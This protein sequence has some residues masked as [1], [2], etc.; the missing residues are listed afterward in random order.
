MRTALRPPS[1]ATTQVGFE[2]NRFAGTLG[3]YRH[4]GAVLRE[5]DEAS[6]PANAGVGMPLQMFEYDF[7]EPVLPQRETEWPARD[8]PN[9]IVV[10]D[11]RF[12]GFEDA[13]GSL[14]DRVSGIQHVVEDT[15]TFEVREN[16]PGV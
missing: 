14:V 5:I 9:G 3:A 6:A 13:P 8:V 11:D 16:R 10:V 1:P 4:S 15:E 2:G 7:G 12:A